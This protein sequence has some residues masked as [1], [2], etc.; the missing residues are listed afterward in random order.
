MEPIFNKITYH[1]IKTLIEVVNSTKEK[2]YELIKKRFQ[3]SANNFECT[4]AFLRGLKLSNSKSGKIILTK[5][6]QKF[7]NGQPLNDNLTKNFLLEKT[8]NFKNN[9]SQEVFQYLNNFKIVS[10]KFSYK[11]T[12]GK[13]LKES[14]IRNLFIE[15]DLIDF[16]KASKSYKIINTYFEI[17]ANYVGG[18]KLSP[19]ALSYLL[20]KKEELGKAAEFEIMKYEKKRLAGYPKLSQHLEHISKSDV[21]AGYDIKSWEIGLTNEPTPRYVEVK[22]VSRFNYRFNWTRNEVEKARLYRQQY[23][24][25]LLPVIS[26]NKFDLYELKIIKNPFDKVFK[27]NV[28]WEKQEEQYSLWKKIE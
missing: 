27:N 21:K 18:K 24:L 28:D 25:Y 8:L 26:Q 2:D 7:L 4:L 22:A 16:D 19:K 9:F 17:F 20:K 11:P 3:S 10:E 15:L 6:F 12:T 5:D 13:R 1:K 23:Y 14:G